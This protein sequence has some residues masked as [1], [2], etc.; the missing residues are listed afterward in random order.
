MRLPLVLS[1]S[2]LVVACGGKTL[3]SGVDDDDGTDAS[4]DGAIT[5][6]GVP[7]DWT[8]C[9]G[10]GQ[11]ALIART[12][13]GSCATPTVSDMVAVHTGYESK[14]RDKVCGPTPPACPD[15]APYI[16]DDSLQAWCVAGRCTAIDVRKESVSSCTTDSD[17]ML[18]HSGCCESCEGRRDDLVALSKASIGD[19]RAKVCVGDEAC[20]RCMPDYPTDA[21]A[22]CDIATK[23]CV[24]DWVALPG[25]G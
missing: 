22:R 16:A 14:Y 5:D 20:P 8:S 15:C 6:T 23:H 1:F 13:C 4:S 19:Y 18:R 24:V 12:C 21:M 17:C 25:G 7:A 2:L 9:S 10:A 11:C 3:E